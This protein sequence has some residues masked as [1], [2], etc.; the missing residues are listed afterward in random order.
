MWRKHLAAETTKNFADLFVNKYTV[1]FHLNFKR[2]FTCL[3]QESENKGQEREE[4]KVY[5]YH[6]IISNYLII[7]KQKDLIFVKVFKLGFTTNTLLC[8]VIDFQNENS[9]FSVKHTTSIGSRFS[10][11][12]FETT[13]SEAA[14]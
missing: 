1:K 7:I 2:R 6:C 13:D 14:F 4:W 10:C 3:S 12:C 8:A 5:T 9:A 11:C